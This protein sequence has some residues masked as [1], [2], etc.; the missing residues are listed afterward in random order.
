MLAKS[1]FSK[2]IIFLVLLFA[3]SFGGVVYRYAVTSPLTLVVEMNS[4]SATPL[5]HLG[6]KYALLHLHPS[7]QE[8]ADLNLEAGARYFA[9][10]RDPHEARLLLQHFSNKGLNINSRDMATGSGLTAL[11]A[12]AISNSPEAVKILLEAKADRSIK[13]DMGRTAL[14]LVVIIQKNRANTDFSDVLALL[15]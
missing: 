13:D 4:E 15:R 5:V 12:A 6:A 11:Q 1:T 9:D 3:V 2:I 7:K 10:L 14:D 8:V